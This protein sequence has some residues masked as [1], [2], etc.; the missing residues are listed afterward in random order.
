MPPE[1]FIIE[2]PYK[3]AFGGK[4]IWLNIDICSCHLV[5]KGRLADIGIATDKKSAGIWVDRG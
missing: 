5:D 4:G 3:K 1:I 2:M